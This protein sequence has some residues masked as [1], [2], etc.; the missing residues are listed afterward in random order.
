VI[1]GMLVEQVTG[2]SLAQEMRQRI[3]G[4]LQLNH[5]FFAPDEPIEGIVAQGYIDDSDR[6]NVS[7]TFV[8]GTA[9]L[10]ASIDD[11]R[12]FADGLF[13]GRLLSPE[14]L[15]QMEDVKDT[16][17]AYDMPE[18]AYGLGLM[19]ARLNV[20]PAADGSQR[21]FEEGAAFGH[22][23]GVAGFR[24]AVWHMPESDIT[25]A[26]SLNQADLDPNILARDILDLILTWQGR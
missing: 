4:P 15:A 11:L 12:R 8:F 7:M 25:I 13:D 26:L 21:P 16:G 3:L 6:A 17:G 20:G 5:T 18:L 14:M 10:I 2:R 23:G 9:N 22:I 19:S 1:L 24:S